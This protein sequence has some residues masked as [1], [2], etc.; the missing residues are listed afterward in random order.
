MPAVK[1]GIDTGQV[2]CDVSPATA[3]LSYSGR[4]M[5]RAARVADKCP[6][7]QV[8]CSEDTVL[9]AKLALQAGA[10][11]TELVGSFELKVC[12]C[13][14]RKTRPTQTAFVRS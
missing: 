3:R 7:G 12:L 11:K 1:I 8:W 2:T 9:N 10:F 5:N 14:T 4:P 13:V 6:S